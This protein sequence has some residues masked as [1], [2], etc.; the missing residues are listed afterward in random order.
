MEN[1]SFI[2]ISIDAEIYFFG[3]FGLELSLFSRKVVQKD[4]TMYSLIKTLV[5]NFILIS[6]H[7]QTYPIMLS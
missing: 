4:D 1:A 6:W 3:D 7:E 5:F 2:F